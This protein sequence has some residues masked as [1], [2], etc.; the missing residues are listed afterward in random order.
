MPS[1]GH[2]GAELRD[3]LLN[4]A[5]FYTLKEAKMLIEQWR[6]HYNTIR[7]HSS[8]AYVWTAPAWQGLKSH[9]GRVVR[10][11][12]RALDSLRTYRFLKALGS[13]SRAYVCR[14]R[15]GNQ[16]LNLVSTRYGLQREFIADEIPSMGPVKRL[17]YGILANI[18]AYPWIQKEHILVAEN[19]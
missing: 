4:E 15:N 16:T 10:L 13:S 14:G 2:L 6:R 3:E 1:S 17:A 12:T 8:L 7:P 18:G 9:V 19:C 11:G 5:I